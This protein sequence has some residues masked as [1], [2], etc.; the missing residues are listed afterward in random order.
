MS[1]SEY[2]SKRSWSAPFAGES[3]D[4]VIA[5]VDSRPQLHFRIAELLDDNERA[6][7]YL[8]LSSLVEHDRGAPTV[9][10]VGPS[11]ASDREL[12]PFGRFLRQRPM[13]ALIVAAVRP[14][15]QLMS[16]AARVGV[17]DIIDLRSE[18]AQLG[19]AVRACI[20]ELC[21]VQTED[22]RFD[23]GFVEGVQS[24]EMTHVDDFESAGYQDE[25]YENSSYVEEDT[26]D[27]EY[28][29]AEFEFPDEADDGFYDVDAMEDEEST[30]YDGP[31]EIVAVYSAKGGTGKS[32]IASNLAAMLARDSDRPVVL[33][34]AD[35]QFGDLAVMLGIKPERSLADIVAAFD[36]LD[37]TMLQSVL[38]YHEDSGVCVLSSPPSPSVGDFMSGKDMERLLDVLSSYAGHVVVDMQSHLDDAMVSVL[39]RATQLVLVGCS[40]I[41]ALKDMKTGMQLLRKVGV[42]LDSAHLVIN[43][44]AKPDEIDVRQ[45]ER[46]LHMRVDAV[47][48]DDHAVPRSVRS[49]CPL[50][51]GHP[52]SAFATAMEDIAYMLAEARQ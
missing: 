16:W 44:V 32:I 33:L 40:E 43:R 13:T 14:S 11:M 1:I 12:E 22:D 26:N 35:F 36:R 41:P 51:V 10:V 21:P 5:I 20:D 4:H 48:G 19:A 46:T 49:R 38:S 52:E 50:V 39:L 9:I 15:E 17:N 42:S 37:E 6:R 18:A 8:S 34:D 27:D 23:P 2:S 28:A 31:G 25:F 7:G 3:M 47:V 30:P 45:I 29:Y 24:E